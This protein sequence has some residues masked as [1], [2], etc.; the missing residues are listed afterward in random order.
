MASI[1]I[2]IHQP[3]NPRC[4]ASAWHKPTS[5]EGGWW[6]YSHFKLYKQDKRKTVDFFCF[7]FLI[8]HILFQQS[9]F[10]LI[11]YLL[12]IKNNELITILWKNNWINLL[13]LAWQT[14]NLDKQSFNIKTEFEVIKF[15]TPI[16]MYFNFNIK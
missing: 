7:K 2:F 9:I 12:L 6:R 13:E 10:I 14:C 1:I 8:N 3:L 4:V 11:L 15:K 16:N 5:Y